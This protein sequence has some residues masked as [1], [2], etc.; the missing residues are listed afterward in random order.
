VPGQ[1]QP[2]THDRTA[3]STGIYVEPPVYLAAH[4]VGAACAGALY[5]WLRARPRRIPDT[6][7]FPNR[8]PAE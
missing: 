8:S 2:G 1:R 4:I 6:I 5:R 3:V 7:V